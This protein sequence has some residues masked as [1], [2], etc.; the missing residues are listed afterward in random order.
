VK[1]RYHE[2]KQR[3]LDAAQTG[4]QAIPCRTRMKMP[5]ILTYR[6]GSYI[7]SGDRQLAKA[8]G[9]NYDIYANQ[10]WTLDIATARRLMDYADPSALAKLSD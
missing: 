5:N 6:D 4:N 8:A 2:R 1:K 3:R 10:F 9:F 7:W